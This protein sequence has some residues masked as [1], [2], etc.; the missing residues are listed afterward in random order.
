MFAHLH[1][2][3]FRS[4]SILENHLL[5]WLALSA[6]YS[7]SLQS[8]YLS[9]GFQQNGVPILLSR[10][11]LKLHNN[12]A[13]ALLLQLSSLFLLDKEAQSRSIGSP[14]RTDTFPSFSMNMFSFLWTLQWCVMYVLSW[15]IALENK[16]FL[17]R[18]T[19]LK[20]E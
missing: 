4:L 15:F 17:N 5:P 2:S 8:I 19:N 11:N 10:F 7:A 12:I 13:L 3:V 6:K 18:K 1:R 9:E 16:Y 14:M 20:I